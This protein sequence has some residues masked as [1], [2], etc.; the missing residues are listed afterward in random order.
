MLAKLT[1]H[2]HSDADQRVRPGAVGDQHVNCWIGKAGQTVLA[3]CRDAGER[4]AGLGQDADPPPL[5]LGQR[6]VVQHH[7][8]AAKRSPSPSG[9]LASNVVAAVAVLAQLVA[10]DDAVLQPGQAV[11]R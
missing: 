6:P 8:E 10:S 9:H 5:P 3:R 11:E 7:D 2:M 1:R 4:A